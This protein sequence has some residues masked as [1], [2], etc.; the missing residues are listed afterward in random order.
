VAFAQA[1]GLKTGQ[2]LGKSGINNA[3][4]LVDL[5]NDFRDKRKDQTHGGRLPVQGNDDAVLRGAVRLINGTVESFYNALFCTQD[6]H[7]PLHVSFASCWRDRHGNPLDIAQYGGAACMTL[8]DEKKA[9]FRCYGFNAD[10]PYDIGYYRRMFD[11]M[12]S[13]EYWRH[14][15]NTGQGDIWVFATH[16]L[17]GTDGVNMHPLMMEAVQFF[18]G[19]R[20]IQPHIFFKGHIANTDWFGGLRPCRPDASHAQGNWQTEIIDTFQNFDN[21]DFFGVAED[22]CVYHT[23]GQVMEAFQGTQY[24][25]K[26]RFVTDGTAPIVPGAQHVQ[27]QNEQARQL[28][29]R[30]ITH[31]APLR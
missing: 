12:D 25:N 9:V 21:I 16:C 6:G 14:L 13:V 8:H 27:D 24:F 3:L 28:G 18:C 20:S 26:L 2:E 10:G 7:P 11:P 17:L 22:F 29:V 19:A 30:F 4:M 23:E 15:Q 5:E 31:D 1:N